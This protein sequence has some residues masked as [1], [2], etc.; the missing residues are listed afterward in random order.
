MEM[1]PYVPIIHDYFRY[2]KTAT[3]QQQMDFSS[4]LIPIVCTFT[5]PCT[6]RTTFYD[7]I[8]GCGDI[9]ISAITYAFAMGTDLTCPDAEGVF[10]VAI[11]RFYVCAVTFIQVYYMRV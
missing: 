6:L 2:G 5:L 7:C 1:C 3:T 9:C 10:I 8:P 4:I 11:V